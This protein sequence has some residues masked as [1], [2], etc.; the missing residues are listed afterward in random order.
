MNI[1]FKQTHIRIIR[2][3]HNNMIQN[4]HTVVSTPHLCIHL[5]DRSYIDRIS[6]HVNCKSVPCRSHIIVNTCHIDRVLLISI[7]INCSSAPY[8]SYIDPYSFYIGAVSI[9]YKSIQVSYRSYI[10]RI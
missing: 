3:Q 8:R 4:R 6:N 7:H 1:Q 10:D 5:R 2:N 9:V